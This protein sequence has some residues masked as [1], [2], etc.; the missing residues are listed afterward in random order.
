MT[1]RSPGNVVPAIGEFAVGPLLALASAVSFGVS[2]VAGA[3][4]TRRSAAPSVAIGIVV[5]GALLLVPL[6][7]LVPGTPSGRALLWG[8]AAGLVGN[9]GLVLYLRCMAL[10]PI[11]VISPI[12]GLVGAGIPVGWGAVIVGDDLGPPQVLGILLGLLA[13]VAVAYVPGTSLRESGGRGPVMAL[14]A[15]VSFGL[16]Y[17]FLDATPDASGLWPLVGS[18]L[19]G[20]LPVAAFALATGRSLVVPRV[21][22]GLTV[23]AGVT[24]VAANALFLLATRSG[25]L[26]LV[27][28][29]SSLYP[30][31]A[32]VIARLV[33]VER[34]SRLQAAGVGAALLA[35]G[36][37]VTG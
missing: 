33:L 5:S 37:L 19:V 10:G 29:L 15:G 20:V 18:R 23:V 28:L 25:L 11:G 32:L 36:L 21:A 24:D 4:A 26:S 12:A 31:V 7:V 6:L 30:V 22:A 14:G 16:F 35:T 34:L 8:S 3:V 17:L 9:V 13:V 27:A 2:D 1:S